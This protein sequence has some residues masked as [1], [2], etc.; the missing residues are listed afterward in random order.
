MINQIFSFTKT[1][2]EKLKIWGNTWAFVI[3]FSI[4][5]FLT[6][7]G[8]R[9]VTGFLIVDHWSRIP[10]SIF[11][12]FAFL[13]FLMSLIIAISETDKYIAAFILLLIG[14]SIAVL[15]YRLTQGSL[16]LNWNEL[17]NDFYAN[18][19]A[20]MISIAITVMVI[21]SLSKRLN[22]R[23]YQREENQK[24]DTIPLDIQNIQEN[25]MKLHPNFLE[26]EGEK[27]FAVLPY[28]EF[29]ALQ[30]ELQDYYDLKELRATKREKT[31]APTLNFDEAEKELKIE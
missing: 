8:W 30:E 13:I 18:I 16:T 12:L 28:T 14:A 25:K 17:A 9:I 24:K 2:I 6:L 23:K 5:I 27:E 22:W 21:E 1:V 20:E 10:L 26:K 29:L 31:D 15:G 3:L 7:A 4:V 19:S 11:F